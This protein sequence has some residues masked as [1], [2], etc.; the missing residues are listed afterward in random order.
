MRK[1]RDYDAELRALNEKARAL[2]AK[3]VEQ[4]GQLVTACGADAL[5]TETL[6][7]VLVA[8]VE[9]SAEEREAWRAKGTAY[10]QQRGRKTA[11]RA[12]GNGE[13]GNQTGAGEA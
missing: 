5:D 9:A 11:R 7:G 4:L 3:K 2:K 13:G 6:A 12:G 10:F 8:A 1:V